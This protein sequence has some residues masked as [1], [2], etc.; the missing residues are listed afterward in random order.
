MMNSGSKS[1]TCQQA[2]AIFFDR[3]SVR[4]EA[5]MN[6]QS[7]DQTGKKSNIFYGYVVVAAAFLITIV[8]HGAQHTFGIFFKPLLDHFGWTKAATSA[9]F[10]LY[11]VLYGLLSIF[12]GRMNDRLGPRLVMT[13]CAIFLGLGYILMSQ[14]S[15]IWHLY[16]FYGVMIAVG[17]SGSWVPLISTIPRWFVHRRGL[18]TGIVTSGSGIG[19]ILLSMLASALIATYQWR[20]SYIV[21]GVGVLVILVLAAQFLKRD[22]QKV[23]QLPHG[24]GVIKTDAP[25]YAGEGLCFREA[26]GTVRF[27]MLCAMFFCFGFDLY[28]VMVHI[29]AHAI[30]LG[31]PALKAASIIAVVGGVNAAGRVTI[32][33]AGDRIGNMRCLVIS[34]VLMTAALLLL[35]I[36]AEMWRLYLFAIIFGLGYGGLAAMMAPVPAELFGLRS[37]GTIVG[38]VMCSF[39]LGGAIGPVLAGH[40]SDITG[41]YHTAFL[42]CA[43]VSA[44]GT[45]LSLLIRPAGKSDGGIAA[46]SL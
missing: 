11:L 3:K 31:I 24:G 15:A 35:T 37:I 33:S 17:M 42:V 9:P 28:T 20:R 2:R 12:V 45:L 39:T 44:A 6:E 21:V 13:I 30:E 4:E 32:G 14:V 41:S 34:F 36:A 19:T 26:V 38:A 7:A 29:V 8:A 1:G 46:R 40:L 22:P 16:L 18:M 43:A 5:S 10:S 27:W 23:G 25:Y